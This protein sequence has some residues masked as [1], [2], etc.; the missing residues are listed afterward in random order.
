M[1]RKLFYKNLPELNSFKKIWG[2]QKL[3]CS[4]CCDAK[5]DANDVNAI[6]NTI[7][8]EENAKRNVFVS[9][10][11]TCG[12]LNASDAG[13]D[14][15]LC[16]WV[17]FQRMKKFI[18]IRD[19]YG[20]TQL[21]LND[22]KLSQKFGKLNIESVIEVQGRVACR[23]QGEVNDNMATGEIEVHVNELK[24]LNDARIDI[25]FIIRDYNNVT[26]INRLSYRYIDL[27]HP[28]MQR[29]LRLRSNVI[30]KMRQFL[31][32]YGFIEVETPTLFKRTP[33]VRFVF[34]L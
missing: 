8:D 17:Q 9:R 26:E 15:T 29:N 11:H 7:S 27:R 30:M 25:P 16:G 19:S 24:I 12:Q 6:K 34:L 13:K 23:P 5:T 33:G 1:L 4:H 10:S 28:L 2:K 20:S 32:E 14:V 31:I 22:K 18:T 3:R 21:F